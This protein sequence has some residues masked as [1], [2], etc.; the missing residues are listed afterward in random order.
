MSRTEVRPLQK[1][2]KDRPLLKFF[3][4]S[5][6]AGCFGSGF[7]FEAGKGVFEHVGDAAVAGFGS[8]ARPERGCEQEKGKADPSPPFPRQP[9]RPLAAGKTR[10]W[11]RDDNWCAQ[12]KRVRTPTRPRCGSVMNGH[13][14]EPVVAGG[15][16]G[17]EVGVTVLNDGGGVAARG[18]VSPSM[19]KA[20]TDS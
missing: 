20:A 15:A 5:F 11:V 19:S 7:A 16:I 12:G 6:T 18:T 1:R 3:V 2:R 10:D 9:L 13:E 14:L 4:N 17:I 8:A